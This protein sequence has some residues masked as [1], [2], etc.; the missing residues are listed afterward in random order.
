MI[1]LWLAAGV[2]AAVVFGLI[3]LLSGHPVLAGA[4]AARGVY[5]RQLLEIDDLATRGLLGE[6]ERR[7]SHAEA[8]RRLL[9]E[10]DPE[11]EAAPNASTRNIAIAVGACVALLALG[12]YLAAGRPQAADQPFAKR[13]EAMRKVDPS[14][15]GPAQME[16]L[17]KSQLKGKPNDPT[18]L[19]YLAQMQEPQG[20]FPAAARNLE[21]SL[22]ADPSRAEAWDL[23][24][25]VRVDMAKGKVPADAREAFE[26]AL[27]IDPKLITSRYF[28]AHGDIADGKIAEGIAGLRAIEADAPPQA[29]AVLEREIAEAQ[30]APAPDA[31]TIAA[32]QAA[33]PANGDVSANP[34]ILAMVNSLATRLKQNPD[35]VAGWERLVRS[36]TVLKDPAGRDKALADARAYFKNRPADLAAIEQAAKVEGQ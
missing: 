3:V 6:D 25:Q 4:D 23:L 28:L 33:T 36:Y 18:G 14:T 24:G 21:K 31:A 11:P 15:L 29:R 8:A 5:R 1:A 26:K 13:L 30:G 12:V 35:D 20:E 27:A 9:S 2:L 17:I 7:A 19:F 10:E 32:V 34:A 22:A 16:A